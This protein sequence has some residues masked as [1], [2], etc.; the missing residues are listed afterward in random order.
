VKGLVECRGREAED[1]GPA[2]SRRSFLRGEIRFGEDCELSSE[3]NNVVVTTP[4][5]SSL[6]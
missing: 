1:F 4:K 5:E 3:N 2:S 6:M